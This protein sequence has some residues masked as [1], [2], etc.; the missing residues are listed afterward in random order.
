MAPA[1]SRPVPQQVRL[2][3]GSGLRRI[4]CPDQQLQSGRLRRSR[5]ILC[6][7]P[8]RS[9]RCC[10]RIHIG[11]GRYCGHGSSHLSSREHARLALE[12]EHQ[13][14]AR[15]AGRTS[16][17][18]GSGAPP[19]TTAVRSECRSS[20]QLATSGRAVRDQ[21]KADRS[22]YKWRRTSDKSTKRSIDLSKWPAGTC[23]SSENS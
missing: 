4:V 9:R 15:R 19:R 1:L 14:E 18:R 6:A 12:K 3:C 7:T 23:R 21:S 11:P 16:G 13:H 17:R 10:S 20:N 8:M 2:G 22:S 5:P